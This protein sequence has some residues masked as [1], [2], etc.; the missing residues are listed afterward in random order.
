MI[1]EIGYLLYLLSS[2]LPDKLIISSWFKFITKLRAKLLNIMPNMHIEKDIRIYRNVKTNK[3]SQLFIKSGTT[4]KENC[5]LIGN[6]Q[7]GS[8]S[9]ILNNSKI[10]GS[11]EVIIGNDTHIGREN[12]IFSHYHDISKKDIL[13]NH[14]KEIFQ[15]TVIGDNVMLFSRVGV[16]SGVQIHN[17]AVIAYGSV[18][19]KNCKAYGIYAGIP[20]V[21]IKERL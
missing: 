4:I 7:I 16:M 17:G 19:T 11:G 8:N 15:K 9:N 2:K 3:K 5:I 13:V 21:F 12:D 20:A 6:I 18:V 10:D 14:S 1:N